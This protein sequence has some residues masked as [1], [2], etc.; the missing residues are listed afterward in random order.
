MFR[1]RKYDTDT[2]IPE[3]DCSIALCHA[4]RRCKHQPVEKL[5]LFVHMSNTYRK[6]EKRS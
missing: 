2:L 4:V 5:S 6:N 3:I 1:L